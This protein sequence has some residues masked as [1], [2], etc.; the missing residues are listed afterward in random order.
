MNEQEKEARADVRFFSGLMFGELT[1]FLT[2]SGGLLKMFLSSWTLPRIFIAL[3]GLIIAG[4]F[5]VINVRSRDWVEI[6]RAGAEEQTRAMP[7]WR[8]K[9]TATYATYSLF[10][11]A[12]AAWIILLII[13]VMQLLGQV[14]CV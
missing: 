9:L 12:A 14:S 6:S 13:S 10:A 7:R 1:I 2:V 4:V 3:T 8:G 5:F 11:Y